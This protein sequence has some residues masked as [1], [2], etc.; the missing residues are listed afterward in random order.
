MNHEI[1][2]QKA[3]QVLSEAQNLAALEDHQRLEDIH[4][5]LA[6]L[7][8]EQDIIGKILSS[9]GADSANLANLT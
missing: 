7:Q 1:Y 5:L 8:E 4:L 2:T 6:L 9:M 3:L